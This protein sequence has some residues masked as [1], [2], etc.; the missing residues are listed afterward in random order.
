MTK[1][2][3]KRL[4]KVASVHAMAVEVI[5]EALA[6]MGTVRAAVVTE[7]DRENARCIIA[8]LIRHEPPLHIC[9]EEEMK[10]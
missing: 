3:Q 4:A 8:R 2:D 10:P 6:E 7:R 1:K 9:A 5:A